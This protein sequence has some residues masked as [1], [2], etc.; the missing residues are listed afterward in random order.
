MIN[1][2][3]IPKWI[4]KEFKT[5]AGKM[6]LFFGIILIMFYSFME[7]FYSFKEFLFRL[8]FRKDPPS[9]SLSIIYIIIYFIISIAV[10]SKG[11]K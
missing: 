11:E 7:V 2:K 6:N 3:K 8:F 9:E 4:L 10:V 1:L 5:E